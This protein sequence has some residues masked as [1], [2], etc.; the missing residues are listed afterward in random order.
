[1]ICGQNPW[2]VVRDWEGKFWKD[3]VAEEGRRV[4]DSGAAGE[5]GSR[6]RPQRRCRSLLQQY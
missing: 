1:M 2:Y 6:C 3:S 4:P 5:Q